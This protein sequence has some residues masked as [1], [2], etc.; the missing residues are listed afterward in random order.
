MQHA[1]QFQRTVLELNSKDK[2]KI[3]LCATRVT[4]PSTNASLNNLIT[5]CKTTQIPMQQAQSHI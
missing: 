1:P 4:P 5:P 3:H 2:W